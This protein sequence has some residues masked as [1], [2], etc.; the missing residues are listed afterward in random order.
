MKKV[1][2]VLMDIFPFLL[3]L[4]G[5]CLI[6]IPFL[7]KKNVQAENDKSLVVYTNN[8]SG[9]DTSSKWE[10]V[11]AYNASLLQTDY[12]KLD[13]ILGYIEIDK[14]N[15]KYPIYRYA[16]D[17]NLEKGIA[18]VD[19]TSAPSEKDGVHIFLLGHNGVY[20]SDLF[21]HLDELSEGD[22]VIIYTLDKTLTYEVTEKEIKLPEDVSYDIDSET[23]TLT[24]M[25]CTPYG[26]NTHRLLVQCK[27]K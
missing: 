4:A 10:L 2:A 5:I 17:E 20:N 7:V 18:H 27:L 6:V 19:G 3:I 24:L 11:D 8:N 22:E 26:V 13:E 23:N 21:T 12:D 1:K 16:T 25:T 15:I 14:L 9:A